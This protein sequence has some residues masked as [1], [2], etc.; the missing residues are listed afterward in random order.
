MSRI[1]LTGNLFISW[2]SS[3]INFLLF[4]FLFVRN[5]LPGY[6]FCLRKIPGSFSRHYICNYT[7]PNITLHRVYQ[8]NSFID[9]NLIHNFLYKLHKIKFL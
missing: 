4:D 5:L 7:F 9:T 2:I 6:Q 1:K 3:C 8:C